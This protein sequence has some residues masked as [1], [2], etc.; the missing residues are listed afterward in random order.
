VASVII[1]VDPH[2]R[3]ATIEAINAR[4]QTVRQEDLDCLWTEAAVT[5][6]G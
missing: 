6:A 1:G 3:S 4:E 5:M 2:K